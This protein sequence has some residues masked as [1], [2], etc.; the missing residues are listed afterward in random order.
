M[1]TLFFSANPHT[2]DHPKPIKKMTYQEMRELSY[3]GFSV[4]H[5]EALIPAKFQLTLKTRMLRKNLAL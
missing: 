2:I 4:F 3:A 5:D 1:L